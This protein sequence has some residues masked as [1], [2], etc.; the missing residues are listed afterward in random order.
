M[1]KLVLLFG[2]M[3]LMIGGTV[4]A[5]T[6][7]DC[8][9]PTGDGVMLNLF[10]SI[11]AIMIVC[12]YLSINM[13][14]QHW[15]ISIMFLLLTLVCLIT[16]VGMGT[17]AVQ[18]M[19]GTQGWSSIQ[20]FYTEGWLTWVIYVPYIVLVYFII[21]LLWKLQKDMMHKEETKFD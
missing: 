16:L 3:T 21:M 19:N 2:F 7:V 6:C 8:T 15:P 18:V 11:I 14:D 5:S 10:I 9:Y 4:A 17:I 20:S 13:G 1:N 12:A